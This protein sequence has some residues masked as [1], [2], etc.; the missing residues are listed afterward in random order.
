MEIT[1]PH[2][3][4]SFFNA[5]T[6]Y[7]ILALQLSV[8][9]PPLYRPLVFG[10]A[11]GRRDEDVIERVIR[12]LIP[13][14]VGLVIAVLLWIA[15]GIALFQLAAGMSAAAGG[16]MLRR[17]LYRETG[18]TLHQMVHPWMFHAAVLRWPMLVFDAWT[19]GIACLFGLMTL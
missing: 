19:L 11:G 12:R 3:A 17:D 7:M 9:F 5:A 14:A 6:V 13:F 18:G 1:F 15:T 16:V 10:W 2:L 4:G 8:G